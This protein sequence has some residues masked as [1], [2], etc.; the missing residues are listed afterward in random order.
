MKAVLF[1]VQSM[2]DR[3]PRVR[4]KAEVLVAEGY[5]VDVL[6]LRTPGGPSTYTLNGVNV[7]TLSLGKKRGSP[8]RYAFEY[9][10][11]FVWAFA[12][13]TLQ[14][15]RRRYVVVDTNTLPDFLVFAA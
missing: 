14:T 11:F 3:D 4:R 9:L 7:R 2:Y 12:R 5:S 1:V 6:S 10:V 15:R 13:T 8:A